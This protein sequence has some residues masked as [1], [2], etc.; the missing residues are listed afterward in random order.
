MGPDPGGPGWRSGLGALSFT[1][2]PN[3]NQSPGVCL[4]GSVILVESRRVRERRL[5]PQAGCYVQPS[6]FTSTSVNAAA[7]IRLHD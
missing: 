2:D 3:F 4:S 6:Y 7:A 1:G 5:R